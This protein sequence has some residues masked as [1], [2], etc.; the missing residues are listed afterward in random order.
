MKPPVVA[1]L[2]ALAVLP[3]A[4]CGSPR[5]ALGPVRPGALADG[6]YRGSARRSI[7]KEVVDVTVADGRIAEVK[8]VGGF[9]SHVGRRAEKALPQA[10]V[11]G[12]STQ[13]DGVSGATYSSDALRAAVQDALDKARR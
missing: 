12:Q 5:V 3:L 2:A 10:I 4:G 9:A 8:V 11:E 6:T 13:V 1:M 7:V